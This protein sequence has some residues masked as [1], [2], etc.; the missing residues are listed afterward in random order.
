MGVCKFLLMLLELRKNK[1]RKV[2]I[3]IVTKHSGKYQVVLIWLKSVRLVPTELQAK[4]K[5]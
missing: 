5:S 1:I 2:S 4:L 3:T